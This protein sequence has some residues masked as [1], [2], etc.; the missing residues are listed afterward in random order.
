MALLTRGFA[1]ERGND[2]A[3]ADDAGEMTWAQLDIAVNQAMNALAD[4]GIG[5]GDTIAIVAGNCNEWFILSLACGQA[6]ITFVPVN[7][8][9][10]APELAYIFG[11][12]DAKAV[13]TG[14]QFA[15]VVHQALQDEQSANVEQSVAFI[16]PEQGRADSRF[17]DFNALLDAANAGEAEKQIMGG[18][19]FYTSG[20]TGHPKGV[21]GSL[22]SVGDDVTA[23][24]WQLVSAGF[25]SLMTVPGVTVLCGPVYH[26]AQWAFS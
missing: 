22:T 3:L 25:A 21:R 9:L 6:G 24:I 19:M 5:S 13:F 7:W 10:V 17:A 12:S 1:Q 2:L 16:D 23:E 26:S 4:M 20:T 8:H 11:D 14:H 18:P 15:D